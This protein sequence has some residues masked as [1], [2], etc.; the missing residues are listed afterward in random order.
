MVPGNLQKTR[1]IVLRFML[2]SSF[3]SGTAQK[4]TVETPSENR[5]SETRMFPKPRP[6]HTS[7]TLITEVGTEDIYIPHPS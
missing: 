6:S 5:Y 1:L 3:P 2:E 7:R 4:S